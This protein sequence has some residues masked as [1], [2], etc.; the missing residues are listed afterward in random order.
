MT[1]N[2]EAELVARILQDNPGRMI[3][4]VGGSRWGRLFRP[5]PEEAARRPDKG[6]RVLLIGSWTL[7]LLAL[8]ALLALEEEAPGEVHLLGLVTDDP[9]DADAKISVSRRFW[10]YYTPEE[11]EDYEWAL[12]H[13][14]LGRGLPCYTGEVKCEAF[15]EL[16]SAW[17]PEAIVVA[18]FGQVIDAAIIEAPAHGIYN[19]HPSDLLHHHGAGPQPWED[20]AERKA[21]HNRVTLHRVSE[22]VDEG[23]V[24][25]RSPAI[26]V[27][28]EDGSPCPDVRLIGEKSLVPVPA[29]VR[30]LVRALTRRKA[31][32]ERGF[33][34]S[35]DFHELLPSHLIRRLGHPIRPTRH[36][37]MLDLPEDEERYTV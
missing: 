16:L 22:G 13:R 10:R 14:A 20:I 11:R 12:L 9:L 1:A 31:R 34:S 26:N 19:V 27:L 32:G 37:H 28:M 30:E 7:G 2:L 6:M 17:E 25:G 23:D 36:G 3:A 5:S 18:A 29:M 8:E 21:A 33:L 35:L 15:R 4:R 24:V